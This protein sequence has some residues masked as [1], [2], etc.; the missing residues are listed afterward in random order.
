MTSSDIPVV[1]ELAPEFVPIHANA[2]PAELGDVVD[3]IEDAAATLGR[4]VR[5]EAQSMVDDVRSLI[6]EKPLAAISVVGAVA[7]VF[8]RL[9]R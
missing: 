7:W 4:V 2:T 5:E 3:S 9:M 8:G 6:R 1:P